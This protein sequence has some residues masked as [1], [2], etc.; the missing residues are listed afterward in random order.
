M[1]TYE[2]KSFDTWEDVV[3]QYP[4]MWVVFDKADFDGREVKAGHIMVILPDEDIIDYENKHF[5]EVKMSL[6]TTETVHI[7]DENGNFVGYANGQ[8]G[9]IHGELIDA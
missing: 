5:N 7:T 9:Y 6:R 4:A 3:K 1:I 8:G 2:D